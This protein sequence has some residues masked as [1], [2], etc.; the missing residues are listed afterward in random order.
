MGVLE[1][2]IEYYPNNLKKSEYV[3][4][5]ERKKNGIELVYN[6]DG[7]INERILWEN[8]EIIRRD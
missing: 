1:V 8:G 6:L 4:N 7:S 3:Y 5:L 2:I